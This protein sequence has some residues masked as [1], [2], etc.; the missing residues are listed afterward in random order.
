MLSIWLPMRFSRLNYLL[1]IFSSCCRSLETRAS[2]P[3]MSFGSMLEQIRDELLRLELLSRPPWLRPAS[4]DL[5]LL[6]FIYFKV[7]ENCENLFILL[8]KSLYFCRCELLY[9]RCWFG[10]ASVEKLDR[11]ASASSRLVAPSSDSSHTRCWPLL[12]TSLRLKRL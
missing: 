9:S 2:K 10:Y 12:A 6:F 7:S 3:S 5:V 1:I 11:T 8:L 4:T